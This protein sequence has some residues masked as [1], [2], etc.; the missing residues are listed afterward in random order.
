MVLPVTESLP[1]AAAVNLLLHVFDEGLFIGVA[2]S[3]GREVVLGQD[4]GQPAAQ[5]AGV[6]LV[7][8]Q[9]DVGGVVDTVAGDGAA[10]RS[11]GQVTGEVR[12]IECVR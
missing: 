6:R 5:V 3:S 11:P 2:D 9:E 4:G 8:R 7:Q 10:C 1:V 12:G